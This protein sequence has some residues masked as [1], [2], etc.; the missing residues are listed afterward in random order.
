LAP[1]G[2]FLELGKRELLTTAE[3]AALGGGRRYFAVFLGDQFEHERDLIQRM[4]RDLLAAFAAGTLRPLPRR[5][6]ALDSAAA[7]FRLMAQGRH[8]GKLVLSISPVA[9]A[10]VTVALRP[11][12][13]Y[14]LT[15]GT[16]GIGQVLAQKLVAWGARNLVLVSR[17][18]E[19]APGA[20]A[21]RG[22]LEQA[23]ARVLIAA[24]DVAD[25]AA[26]AA[27]LHTVDA[28]WPPL[29]GVIHAAGVLDDGIVLQQ[30]WARLAAVLAPKLA[31]AWNLH[32]LTQTAPLDFFVCFS[33]VGGL[34][35]AAG[36]AGY[37]AAN[38]FLDSLAYLR[39]AEGL[40]ALTIAWGAWGE[41]GMAARLDGG[42]YRRWT[43]QGMGI[44][45]PEHGCAALQLALAQPQ[46]HLVVAPEYK[47]PAPVPPKQ[48][49]EP[50]APVGGG[51]Q[52]AL[53]ARWSLA[54]VAL[55]RGVLADFIAAEARRTIGLGSETGIEPDVPLQE[56]GLDSLMAVELRN[57][58]GAACGT[59]L[60]ATL[61]FDHPSIAALSD[62]L[63]T[64]VAGLASPA[65]APA[66][67]SSPDGDQ[68]LPAAGNGADV[69]AA[70]SEEEAEA[71]L[72][73]ELAALNHGR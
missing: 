34:Q 17:Q 73:A 23:G 37:A 26:V 33:S 36:Q 60:P 8:M 24:A 50:S 14:L 52:P 13:T 27:L 70:L 47:V 32:R 51:G 56:L 16:G 2:R 58:L 29:R 19:D 66:Q 67:E 48:S 11:D 46:P 7:A 35:G 31:G 4:L 57:L 54:P 49:V 6:F 10:Q 44:I 55:R 61:L 64:H 12:A 5:M 1:G 38:R 43:E 62:F 59:S 45:D 22:D 3:A 21:L 18:G 42:S 15:G 72:L 40:P 69:L 71:L 28:E 68:G 65:P 63:V 9:P 53:I 25:A 20:M 30:T 41:I 39:R